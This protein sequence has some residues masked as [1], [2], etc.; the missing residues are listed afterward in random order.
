VLVDVVP[1]VVDLQGRSPDRWSGPLERLM[2]E[3]LTQDTVCV[4]CQR[5]YASHANLVRHI[6]RKHPGTYAYQ[7]YVSERSK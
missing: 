6:A 5:A 3:P 7:A 2:A 1:M 4:Y